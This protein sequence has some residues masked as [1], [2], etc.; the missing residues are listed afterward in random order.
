ML[1]GSGGLLNV[2]IVAGST[3][4]HPKVEHTSILSTWDIYIHPVSIIVS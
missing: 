4:T 3:G 2:F 1:H